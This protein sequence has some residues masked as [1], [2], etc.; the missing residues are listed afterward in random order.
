MLAMAIWF[1]RSPTSESA[2]LLRMG[3]LFVATT[4][5]SATCLKDTRG[6]R[7][8]IGWTSF[9]LAAIGAAVLLRLGIPTD[10][11][12]QFAQSLRNAFGYISSYAAAAGFVLALGALVARTRS[13]RLQRALIYAAGAAL[14]VP[15]LHWAG[16]MITPQRALLQREMAAFGAIAVAAYVAIWIDAAWPAGRD[17]SARACQ[18]LALGMFVTILF[19]TVIGHAGVAPTVA[20]GLLIGV[21]QAERSAARPVRTR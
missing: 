20:A 12:A 5:V 15:A 9:A 11:I 16:A 19:G 17:L 3:S 4:A 18:G 8:A 7:V 1:V 13:P 14:M 2:G 21:I 6:F 10:V